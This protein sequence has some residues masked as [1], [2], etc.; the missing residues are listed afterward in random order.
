MLLSERWLLAKELA[1][2]VYKRRLCGKNSVFRNPLRLYKLLTANPLKN[3]HPV[4]LQVEITSRCNMS[5]R[6]CIHH[7]MVEN[8]KPIGDMPMERFA[9]ILD[10][11]KSTV[12]LLHIQGQGEPFLHP[13]F[14]EMI[15]EAKRRKLVLL[16]FS[17]GTLWNR[18]NR[19]M[20]LNAGFDLLYLSF[21][22]Q[23]KQRMENHRRGMD[24]DEVVKNFQCMVRE[25][26]AG[27]Y[28]TVLALHSVIYRSDLADYRSRLLE[29]DELMKP[30]VIVPTALAMPGADDKDY[31]Q[32]YTRTGL[33]RERVFALPAMVSRSKDIR[34]LCI[35]N[36]DFYSRRNCSTCLKANFVYYRW[37]GSTSFCGERHT[38]DCDDPVKAVRNAVRL[39]KQGVVPEECRLCQYLPPQLFKKTLEQNSAELR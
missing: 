2:L 24:Y 27:R 5:C 28:P 22:L 33:D 25:R 20:I 26:D 17:N 21:D 13:Q 29:I 1:K 35:S 18:E 38:V 23:T 34:A 3:T 19:R 16:A 31:S 14:G 4:A 37:D 12:Q 39:M 36:R 15:A 7:K 32:W 11:H 6:Y 30:D 9:E 8:D 10:R